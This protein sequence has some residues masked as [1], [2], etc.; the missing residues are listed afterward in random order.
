MASLEVYVR[1]S[2]RQYV[3]HDVIYHIPKSDQF[4]LLLEWHFNFPHVAAGENDG[5]NPPTR[6][7]SISDMYN[8]Q[9]SRR[10]IQRVGIMAALNS[11]DEVC[12]LIY[13]T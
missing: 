6:N 12:L 5:E 2:Y 4:P 7:F 10:E 13:F 1:R 8:I 3:L 9:H 11:I